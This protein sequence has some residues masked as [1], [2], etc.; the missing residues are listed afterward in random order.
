[1]VHEI[2]HNADGSLDRYKARLVAK[3]YSQC[4]GFDF[5]ETFAP[6]VRYSTIRIV[7]ALAAL[8]DL[9]LHS[10]DISHAYLNGTLE[11]EIYMTQPEGFEVGGPDHV[12]KLVKSLYGLKQ[13]GRVWNKTLHSALSSMGFKHV[14]SDHGLYIYLRDDVRLLMPVFVDDITLACKDGAK[15]DSVIQEL[16]QH[17]KLR[18]LGPTTQLLGIEIHRDRPNRQ[19]SI[20]QSQ[21]I[22]NLIQE[23]GLSDSK[24]V[25]TPLNPGTRLSTSMCPQNDAEALEMQQYPYISVVGSLMYL[26]VTT[27][28]DIAYAA[29]VLARFNSNPGPAHW[30]AAK[31]VL[32]YLKGTTQHKLVY[33]PSTSPEPFITY[34]DADH[35]GNP[36]NGKSTGM[37]WP[38]LVIG[39]A[40]GHTS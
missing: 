20:S 15:I 22:S 17:F 29:G 11:E 8:E 19:L 2:K 4:P 9:E 5:K 35:G 28:P 7:L 39:L 34:S 13:A 12:C 1:M 33:Q 25:T 40:S 27:R 24:P 10:V 38:D 31:H 3:G 16:S 6:T 36:D 18:D 26:A 21:F 32:H 23:H 30:Q 14:Q 37:H